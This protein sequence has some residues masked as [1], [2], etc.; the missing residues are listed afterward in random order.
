MNIVWTVYKAQ[1]DGKFEEL[2]EHT[3]IDCTM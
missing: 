3:L 1:A 2:L